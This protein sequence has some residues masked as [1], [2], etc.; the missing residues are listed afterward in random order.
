MLAKIASHPLALLA[1]VASNVVPVFGVIFFGWDLL[2]ILL[3][4]WAENGVIGVFNLLKML[5]AAQNGFLASLP[6]KLF[7]MPFFT[8]HYGIFWTVHGVFIM[9]LFGSDG[10]LQADCSRQSSSFS[11]Q[12]PSTDIST[13]IALASSGGMGGFFPFNNLPFN[14]INEVVVQGWLEAGIGVA[15]LGLIVSHG[16]SFISN[17][18]WQGEFLDAN[19]FALM[20]QPYGRVAILHI[21]ILLGGFLVMALGQAIMALLLLVMLKTGVDIAAHLREHTTAP[22]KPNAPVNLRDT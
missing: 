2:A 3:L 4:Y 18:L 20:F 16:V 14:L 5:T 15:L 10:V 22:A 13:D 7:I 1:L 19:V 11:C 6:S 12:L 21:T 9:T 8:V 17:Y